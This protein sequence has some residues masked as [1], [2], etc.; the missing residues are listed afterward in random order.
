MKQS[1]IVHVPQT[2]NVSYTLYA[3]GIKVD[4]P[5]LSSDESEY[6]FTFL[7]G[8][9]V[10]LFYCFGKMKKAFVVRGWES[11]TDGEPILLPGVDE[12]LALVFSTNGNKVKKLDG[13][14]KK[15]TKSDPNG[16]FLFPALFWYRLTSIIQF[17]NSKSTLVNGLY[18]L[19]A[20]KINE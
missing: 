1:L 7:P 11:E 3:V 13:I 14:I 4:K 19:Y 10:V 8:T 12:K 2:E 16:I 5:V 15:L 6:I 9:P 20:E 18:N 17:R